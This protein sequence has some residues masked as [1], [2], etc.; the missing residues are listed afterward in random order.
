MVL[1]AGAGAAAHH[2]ILLWPFQFLAI[3]AA[4]AAIPWTWAAAAATVVL[5]ASNL[6][7]TNEY[8]WELVRNGPDIRWTDAIY[9]LNRRPRNI[10]VARYLYRRLGDFR[11]D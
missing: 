10:T 7:V 11:I 3:A 6:A 4:L 2:I 5:C 9:P 8:Y 1:T